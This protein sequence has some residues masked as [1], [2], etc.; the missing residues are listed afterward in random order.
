MKWLSNPDQ[1]KNSREWFDERVEQN[2]LS[3]SSWLGLGS[4]ATIRSTTAQD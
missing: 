2:Q 4:V 1:A 3:W